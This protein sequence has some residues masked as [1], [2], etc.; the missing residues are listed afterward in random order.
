MSNPKF[1]KH[2]A[3]VDDPQNRLPLGSFTL[4]GKV[5]WALPAKVPLVAKV[6]QQVNLLPLRAFQ[7]FNQYNWIQPKAIARKALVDDFVNLLPLQEEPG[8][9]IPFAVF[10]WANPALRKVSGAARDQVPGGGSV[11]PIPPS[12]RGFEWLARARRRNRR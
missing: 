5:D 6:D 9:D 3:K 11:G 7:P 12:F 10:D 4:A 2:R 8:L 1:P